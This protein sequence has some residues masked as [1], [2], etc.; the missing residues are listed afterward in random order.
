MNKQ[1]Q[2]VYVPCDKKDALSEVVEHRLTNFPD[3]EAYVNEQ[4]AYL[5]TPEEH[6]QVQKMRE[7]LEEIAKGE[8]F[9]WQER[10]KYALS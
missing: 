9:Y 8:T 10:A 7:A 3:H 4:I 6:A 2:T 5:Y 1:P